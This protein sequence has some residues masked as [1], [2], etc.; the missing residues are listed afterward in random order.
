MAV[1]SRARRAYR[2]HLERSIA[3]A[4]VPYGYT[5]SV[6]GSGMVLAGRLGLPTLG[7][8]LLFVG[9]AVSAF[10][11]LEVIAQRSLRPRVAAPPPPPPMAGWG[12]AHVLSA[13]AAIAAADGGA[14]LTGGHGAWP[15]A[16]FLATAVYLTLA[17]LQATL[18]AER[19]D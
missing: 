4:I 11:L 17:A 9:G 18:A 3:A 14:A 15:L 16:G 19:L 2:A 13:G 8:V 6:A 5:L 7:W 12:A 10:L 1:P